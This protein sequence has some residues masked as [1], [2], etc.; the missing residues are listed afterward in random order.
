VAGEVVADDDL[1][2]AQNGRELGL[3]VGGEH[4]A[5][6]RP[7]ED[8]RRLQPVLAQHRHEGLRVPVSERRMIDQPL[9]TGRTARGLDHVG[10]HRGL[11]HEAEPVQHVAHERL[12]PG[13]PGMPLLA[14]IPTRLLSRAQ[15]F[16][17]WVRPSRCSQA[18]T[19][20]AA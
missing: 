5:V 9:A 11:V 15:V 16:F 6:H 20:G 14:D 2:F 3:G 13:D 4:L 17:L 12:A 8:P 10:L 18:P 1:P 19:V 7:G